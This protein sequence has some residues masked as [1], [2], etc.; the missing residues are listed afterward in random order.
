M[1]SSKTINEVLSSLQKDQSFFSYEFFP[2]K[3]AAV[4]ITGK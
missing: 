3:T 4:S 2:P 1:G